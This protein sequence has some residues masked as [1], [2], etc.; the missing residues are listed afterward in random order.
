MTV[1]K[2]ENIWIRIFFPSLLFLM[3]KT[4]T[5]TPLVVIVYDFFQIE[6]DVFLHDGSLKIPS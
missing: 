2:I 1:I 5:L 3:S 4:R 6:T